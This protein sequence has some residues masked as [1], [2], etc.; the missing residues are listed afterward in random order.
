MYYY[1]RK[2]MKNKCGPKPKLTNFDK[3]RIKRQIAQY[4]KVTGKIN[5]SKIKKSCYLKIYT[6][7]IQRYLKCTGFT[8]VK[9]KSQIVLS[10]KHKEVILEIITNCITSCHPRTVNVTKLRLCM[11]QS[12]QG[13]VK[14]SRDPEIFTINK[15]SYEHDKI[16]TF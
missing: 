9:A 6:R 2:H 12:D 13:Y 15:L 16:L 4:T 3:L 14:Y 8:Y 11:T 7:N 5:A 10:K 1:Q